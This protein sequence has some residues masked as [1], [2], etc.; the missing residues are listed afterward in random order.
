MQTIIAEKPSVAREIAAIVGAT[1]KQEGY[2]E[3]N[4]FAVT[5]ALGHLVSLALPEEYGA[6]GFNRD[7]LPIIPVPFKLI[8]RQQKVDKGYKPDTGAIKQLGVINRLF[9]ECDRIIVA[10]D[11]GREGELIFR[12]I[13]HYLKCT[14]SFDRLWISS[15][16]D[17][18]IREGLQNLK[19]GNQY[20]NLYLAAKARSEA[21]WLVGI[22]AS[23]ALS[24][25]AGQG[26]FSLGRVQTPTLVMIC[27]RFIEN[28]AFLPSKY[29]QIRL[30]TDKQGALFFALSLDKF[31]QKEEAICLLETLQKERSVTVKSIEQKQEN[32]ESPLLY[33][34]TTLQKEANTKLDFSADKTLIIAQKLYEAKLITYPRTG[35]RYIPQDV[36]DTIPEL[37]R[38]LVSHPQFGDYAQSLTTLNRRCVNDKKVTD[39]HALLITENR[40]PELSLDDKAIYEMIAGRMLEAFSEKCIKTVISVMLNCNELLFNAKSISVIQL[41]WRGVFNIPIEEENIVL[42]TLIE[43]DVLSVLDTTLLEKQTKAKPLHTE[44]SLLSAMESAGKE[45]ENEEERLAMKESGIGTPATRAAIIETLFARD[46]IRREKKSLVPTDK[47][48]SVFNVVKDKKIADVQMTGMWEN[49][50]A[51]IESGEMKAN[52][53]RSEIEAYTGLITTEL[54]NTSIAL[55]KQ[56]QVCC[57]RCK[58]TSMH[59]YDKVVKCRNTD[60][61]VIVYR[62]K[63]EKRLTDKQVTELLTTGKTET[64]K[65]FKSKNGKS[66][67]AELTFDNQYNVVFV[68]PDKPLKK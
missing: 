52:V 55:A 66:F 50:L 41:G 64:I 51:K 28:K 59:F 54:L 24:I 40:P 63:S 47:G 46:Y 17:K 13:Y 34:L 32:Q 43:G 27:N 56:E 65:G 31:D 57:P 22:N 33:D 8:V 1:C 53:F 2:M 42:P 21:D 14:K 23:Q 37:I 5:W 29:W 15:L 12:Y 19:V 44:S 9:N 45:L 68:F 61:P 58:T 4:G 25:S 38:N 7:H 18:A 39:H 36:F 3:G 30:Q 20:D 16:T 35:S 67:D 60:C 48:L 49:A 6:I 62:T 11:A 10:T 26:S